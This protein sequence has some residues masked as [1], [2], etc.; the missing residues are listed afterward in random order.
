M[1]IR[2]IAHDKE[3]MG[4]SRGNPKTLMCLRCQH[5]PVPDSEC[6]GT[7]SKIYQDIK[8]SSGCHPDEFSLGGITSLIVQAPKDMARRT[9]VV[10][11][12]KIK[13]DSH[14]PEGLPIPRLQEETSLITEDLRFEKECI[15]DFGGKFLHEWKRMKI[16]DR[17]VSR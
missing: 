6:R 3:A 2:V 10:I 14:I 7:L 12:N 4:A 5:V 17:I 8:D 13:I 16:N 9:G 1:K 15:V 11:L